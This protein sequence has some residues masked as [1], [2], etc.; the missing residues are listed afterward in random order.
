MNTALNIS[1]RAI[2]VCFFAATT[3][4][5]CGPSYDET[6][7]ADS[8][9]RQ[10][11]ADSARGMSGMPGMSGQ[12]GMGGMMGTGMM[13]SMQTHMREMNAMSAERMKEMLPMHRQMATN[14]LT[15][16]SSDMR[17]MNMSADAAWTTTADS[18][19]QDLAR[20]PEMGAAELKAVMPSHRGRMT[21][22]MQM[23]RDMVRKMKS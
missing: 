7:A 17:A 13:D 14:M 6:A 9:G 15:R 5:A 2:A 21:R 8:A 20:M 23:H 1:A 12:E 10:T 4:T 3:L 16:M 11:R 22:L 18:V 19:R